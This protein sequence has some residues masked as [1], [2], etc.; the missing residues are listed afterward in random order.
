MP[1]QNQLKLPRKKMRRIFILFGFM[2]FPVFDI[3]CAEAK[4]QIVANKSILPDNESVTDGQLVINGQTIPYQATAGTY[5]Y[6]DEKGVVKAQFFYVAYTRTDAKDPLLRPITF[7]FNGGP[8]AASVFMH[9]GLLGPKRLTVKNSPPYSY[10]DNPFSLLDATDL[11]FIDPI[12]TGYSRPAQGEELKQ[13]HSVDGD[14]KSIAEFIRLYT[15]RK[16]RWESPKYLI[17]ASYGTIRAVKL[18]CYLYEELNMALTGVALI[19]PVLDFQTIDTTDYSNDLSSI[20]FLPAY[21]ATA[22]N[23]QKLDSSLQKD[24][25]ET[26]EKVKDYA[27]NDYALALLQ[28]DRLSPER[29]KET[30]EKLSSYTGLPSSLIDRANLRIQPSIFMKNLLSKDNKILG[31]FDGRVTGVAVEAD[32]EHSEYD[33]SLDAVLSPFTAAFNQYVRKELEWSVDDEYKVLTS[34]HP[35]DYNGATN[36]YL[37]TIPNLREALIRMP[38][39]KVFVASGYYDLAT[40]FFASEYTF[41]RLNIRPSA[42]DRMTLKYYPG[43]HMMYVDPLSIESLSRDLHTFIKN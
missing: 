5:A 15:T 41:N 40:P 23:H 4:E 10:A 7:S 21:T 26:L 11:V 2:L 39:F 29:R 28:G 27:I 38:A 17:G 1:V 32:S 14:V 43:G 35:W 13:F 24:F 16:N 22:L 36:R 12:A 30:I 19:S 34:V 8:G 33:P 31:R 20:L 6:K 25:F 42:A 9:M 18:A 37:N 3:S